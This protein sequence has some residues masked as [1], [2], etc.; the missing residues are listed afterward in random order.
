MEGEYT[1]LA[2]T[3][4]PQPPVSDEDGDWCPACDG[5]LSQGRASNGCAV[6]YCERCRYVW[7]DPPAGG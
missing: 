4:A 6:F 1:S 2:D 7:V 5:P 3:P